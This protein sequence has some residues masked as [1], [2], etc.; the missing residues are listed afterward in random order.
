M[1]FWKELLSPCASCGISSTALFCENCFEK[2]KFKSACTHCGKDGILDS[3]KTCLPCSK[4]SEPWNSLTIAFRLEL[5]VK[6]WI[7]DIKKGLKPERFNELSDTLVLKP[8]HHFDAIVPLC[9]DPIQNLKR[10]FD[11]TEEMAKVLSRLWGRPILTEVFERKPFL[12]PQSLLKK[13]DRERVLKQLIS[14]KVQKWPKKSSILLVD[15]VMT[16]G[17]TLRAHAKLLRPYVS[18]IHVFILARALK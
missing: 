12:S 14:L 16:T 4:N 8:N 1:K 5:P 3:L 13:E 2:L 15:D 7:A 9:S 17:E 18:E 11:P 10:R 6:E